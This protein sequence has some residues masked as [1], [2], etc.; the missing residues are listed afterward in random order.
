MTEEDKVPYSTGLPR[1]YPGLPERARLTMLPPLLDRAVPVKMPLNSTLKIC[2]KPSLASFQVVAAPHA[3][4]SEGTLVMTINAATLVIA[5]V[6]S[7][8]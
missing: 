1:M 6:A 4:K 2:S 3:V 5:L 7:P 8:L